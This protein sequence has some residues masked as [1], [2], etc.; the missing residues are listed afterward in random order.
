MCPTVTGTPIKYHKLPELSADIMDPDKHK[1]KKSAFEQQ[2][3]VNH[4]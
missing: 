1:Q 2:K 4:R 3:A